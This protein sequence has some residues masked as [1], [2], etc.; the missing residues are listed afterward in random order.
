MF[1]KNLK[2]IFSDDDTN[3]ENPIEKLMFHSS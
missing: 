3:L 1:E 2:A